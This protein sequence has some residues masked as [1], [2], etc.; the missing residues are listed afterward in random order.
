MDF[1]F[2]IKKMLPMIWAGVI[3][4]I[5]IL[6]MNIAAQKYVGSPVTKPRLIGVL[7]SKSLQ[8]REI[9]KIL[10]ESGADFQMTGAVE[11]ELVAAGARPEV[12]AAVR[13]NYRSAAK[14]AANN[15]PN[16]NVANNSSAMNKAGLLKTLKAKSMSNGA[17]LDNIE[18][19]GVS[20]QA[21]AADER[22]LA[23]AGA[24]PAIIAA[25]KSSYRGGSQPTTSGAP[26]SKDA[27]VALLQNGI[28]D[29]QV[30]Q[31]VKNRGVNFKMNPS[32]TQEIRSAGGSSSLVN[33]INI[34]F[35]G[36]DDNNN[37]SSNSASSGGSDYDD[38][39][40]QAIET[41]NN[42]VVANAGVGSSGR[43]RAIQTLQKASQLNPNNPSAFQQL[44][45]MTLY[46]TSNGFSA[47]EGFMRKAID[48]GGA[49]VL[50]VYHDHDG[51][52][53]E[54]CTGSLYIAR[55]AVRFESDNNVHTFETLDANIQKVSMNNS[56]KQLFQTKVG[57]FKIVLKSED[58]N[59][60]KFSFAPLT[61]DAQESK[62]VIRLIGK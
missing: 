24:S 46:G 5:L 18:Q 1:K 38:Y 40:S 11:S 51:I 34:A 3:G 25:I 42:D 29:A 7:R 9:V 6:P 57:S 37:F 10:N 2:R 54:T 31:N 28:S 19:N 52:F 35:V 60:T 13:N 14:P 15:R 53:K 56:F 4:A 27:I 43:L 22:E 58:K 33:L 32:A 49:A 17:I 55:D 20:F 21:T 8:T 12:L 39:I 44:G 62:M 45:F 30:Q 50:R 36:S 26:L 23:A 61:N 48:L 41:Y 16:N 47:A 59:G